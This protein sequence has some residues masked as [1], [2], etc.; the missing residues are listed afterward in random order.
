MHIQVVTFTSDIRRDYENTVNCCALIIKHFDTIS[1]NINLAA[2]IFGRI[3]MQ[4]YCK[5]DLFKSVIEHPAFSDPSHRYLKIKRIS[6]VVIVGRYPVI[7]LFYSIL[8]EA[9]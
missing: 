9:F 5:S 6:D 3:N 2:Y 4:E 1:R 8:K 7:G